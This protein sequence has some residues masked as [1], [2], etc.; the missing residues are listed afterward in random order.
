MLRSIAKMCYYATM[1]YLAIDY[2]KKRVGLAISDEEGK[3]AFPLEVIENV[4]DEE[5]L[6]SIQKICEEKGI[7]EV[8]IG[9]SKNFKGDDNTIMIDIKNFIEKFKNKISLPIQMHPEFMTS[10]QVERGIGKNE[11]LDASAA[12]IILQS[13]LDLQRNKI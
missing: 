5:L 1:R 13:H 4:G 2:G 6:D 8:V 11:M 12:A 3:I 7:K 9:E 10:Q